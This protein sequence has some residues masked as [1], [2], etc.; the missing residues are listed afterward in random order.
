MSPAHSRSSTS[1]RRNQHLFDSCSCLLLSTV[2]DFSAMD[3]ATLLE[4]VT[5]ALTRLKTIE[6][7]MGG[8][9]SKR[10]AKGG[11]KRK[12]SKA[13]RAAIGAAQKKRWAKVRAEKAATK[14]AAKNAA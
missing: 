2:I 5:A 8:S 14:K 3:T 11:S 1:S 13:A 7:A 9:T 10:I 12:L 4:E 6:D